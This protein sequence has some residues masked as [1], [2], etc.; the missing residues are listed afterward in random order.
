MFTSLVFSL[1]LFAPNISCPKTELINIRL[2]NP[3]DLAVLKRGPIKCRLLYGS[4]SPC[5]IKLERT[6]E[7]IEFYAICGEEK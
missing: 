5:L 2:N 3:I 4:R 6:E 7:T 1:S